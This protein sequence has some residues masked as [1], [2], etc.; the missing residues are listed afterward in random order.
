MLSDKTLKIFSYR[1]KELRLSHGATQKTF[2]SELHLTPST[3]WNYENAKRFPKLINLV[4]IA[5]HFD[6]SVDY[7][8]GRTDN[9]KIRK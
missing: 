3:I 1:I 6:I 5:D 2:A 4:S 7:L 8:V 9:P